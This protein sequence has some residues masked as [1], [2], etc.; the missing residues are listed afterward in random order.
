M[1]DVRSPREIDA[2]EYELRGAHHHAHAAP[3][4]LGQRVAIFTAIAACLL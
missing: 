2:E 3:T 4:P 1:E